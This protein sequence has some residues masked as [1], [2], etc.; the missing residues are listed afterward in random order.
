MQLIIFLQFIPLGIT[1]DSFCG[2]RKL[3][4]WNCCTELLALSFMYRRQASSARQGRRRSPGTGQL[5][6]STGDHGWSHDSWTQTF[7]MIHFLQCNCWIVNN[8]VELLTGPSSF[9]PQGY[10]YI[11]HWNAATEWPW[12]SFLLSV[13]QLLEHLPH[14]FT[15]LQHPYTA[16]RHMAARCVGVL[17]K[18]AMLDTMNGFLECVLPWLAA[19]DDCTKQEGAIEALACILQALLY[20]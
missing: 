14:L 2:C 18:I 15:C 1:L 16:V 12:I 20:F 13:L 8:V 6:A 3:L 11:K 5:F 19:I 7:G 17:S 9:S 4:L 10:I